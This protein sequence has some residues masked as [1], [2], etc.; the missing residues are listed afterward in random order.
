MTQQKQYDKEFKLNTVQL[1]LASGKPITQ[2]T[3]ELGISSKHYMVGWRSI[4]TTR[5]MLSLAVGT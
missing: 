4:R 1:V 3:R 5:N 2:I